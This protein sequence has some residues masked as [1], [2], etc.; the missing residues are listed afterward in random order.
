MPLVYL[1]VFFVPN[2][3][4][5]DNDEFNQYF[6]PVLSKGFKSGTYHLTIFNRWGQIVFESFNPSFGWDGTYNGKHCQDG[7][8]IWKISVDEER[9]GENRLYHGHVN[10]IKGR[11]E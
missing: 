8:Y 11:A 2:T 6:K 3:F 1:L 7:T 9:T 5:P 10:L 4:T